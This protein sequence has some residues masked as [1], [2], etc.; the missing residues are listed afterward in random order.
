MAVWIA[1]SGQL[2]K[3]INH[4]LWI[5]F[6][7]QHR[8]QCVLLFMSHLD[9]IEDEVVGE[10]LVHLFASAIIVEVVAVK[11][12][13]VLDI[14]QHHHRLMRLFWIAEQLVVL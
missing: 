13:H 7:A 12:A 8:A 6:L 3:L 2:A 11:V 14:L 10:E 9:I 5:C 1:S 4:Y